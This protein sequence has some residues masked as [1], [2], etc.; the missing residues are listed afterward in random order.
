MANIVLNLW[1]SFLKLA[2][3]PLNYPELLWIVTPL[4]MVIIVMTIYFAKYKDE[5]LGWNTAMGNSLILIFVALDLFRSIY[6]KQSL[7]ISNFS[8]YGSATLLS[9]LL[10]LIGMVLMFVNFSHFLPKRLGFLFSSALSINLMA[11]TFIVL[12]YAHTKLT[13]YALISG[14]IL[15]V[16]LLILFL[17]IGILSRNAW[18]KIE[19]EKER[20]I[21]NDVKKESKVIKHEKLKIKEEKKKIKKDKVK[22]SKLK[23][24]AKKGK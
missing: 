21:I 8:V 22:L 20:E 5:E 9:F 17:G 18:I 13:I 15:Y 16:I 11:Y 12:V 19:K 3:A 23:S 1:Q 4:I 7:G 24:A 10:L 6:M 14:V 2:L